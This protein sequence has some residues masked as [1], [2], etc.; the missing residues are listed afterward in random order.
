MRDGEQMKEIKVAAERGNL[1]KVLDFVEGE[2]KQNP[3]CSHKDLLQIHMVIDEI[4]GNIASYAYDD[5]VGDVA[6]MV[7]YDG[8]QGNMILVFSDEGKPYN[9]LQ[10]EDPDVTLPARER[11]IGG[12]GIFM[13]K[14]TMDEIAY[15]NRD[16]KNI[17][18]MKKQMGGNYV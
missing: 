16:G 10:K 15:E 18:T 9:P 5:G 6:V 17:L 14:N 13:V 3:D 12:L 8:T 4:F 1:Q 7:D 2:M 11:S